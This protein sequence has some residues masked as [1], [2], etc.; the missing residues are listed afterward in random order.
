MHAA[1]SGMLVYN[2]YKIEKPLTDRY[3]L[4][5]KVQVRAHQM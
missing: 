2:Q 1:M 5:S 4:E 3:D